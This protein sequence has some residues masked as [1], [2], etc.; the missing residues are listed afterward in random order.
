MITVTALTGPSYSAGATNSNFPTKHRFQQV[1]R[2]LDWHATEVWLIEPMPTAPTSAEIAADATWLVQA[3]DPNSGMTRLV[4][5][6]PDVYHA[7]SFLDDRMLAEPRETAVVPWT[8]IATAI[9]PD[10]RTDARWIFH[11]GHVGSTLIARLLGELPQVLSIREPR[12][13]RDVSGVSE[14]GRGGF[15]RPLQLL[16]SRTFDQSQIALIKATS[17]VSEIAPELVPPGERALFTFATPRAYVAS[18]LAGE[19]STKELA[20]LAPSRSKRVA[21]RAKLPEPSNAAV[22]EGCSR[23]DALAF[24]HFLGTEDLQ[25]PVHQCSFARSSARARSGEVSAAD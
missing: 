25:D 14:E 24:G 10:T 11:I 17:F 9:P 5:M 19:N 13:L 15:I 1:A 12:I 8:H 16:F 7:A 22:N 20:V 2:S 23:R 18:I 3:L 4:R 21:D 6:S